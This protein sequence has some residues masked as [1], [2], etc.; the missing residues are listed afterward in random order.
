MVLNIFH[1]F[2]ETIKQ[3]KMQKLIPGV[4]AKGCNTTS[5]LYPGNPTNYIPSNVPCWSWYLVKSKFSPGCLFNLN[6][7]I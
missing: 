4:K 5:K 6:P 7:K 1:P 3:A 2:I